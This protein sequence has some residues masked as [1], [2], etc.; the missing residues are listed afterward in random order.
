MGLPFVSCIMPTWNRRAFVPKAIEYFLRQDYPNKELVILDDGA[1]NVRDL[2]PNSSSAQIKCRLSG[3]AA[4]GVK[5]NIL[6]REAQ[7]DLIAHWHDDDWY[8][9]QRLSRQVAVMAQGADICGLDTILFHDLP[10]DKTYVYHHPTKRYLFCS[11]VMYRR[12]FW[13]AQH[14]PERDVAS[15]S[16]FIWPVD[17]PHRL[18]NAVFLQDADWFVG[19]VHLDNHNRKVYG[20]PFYTPYEG[21]VRDV[22]GQDWEFYERLRA[23]LPPRNVGRAA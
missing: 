6:V 17:N 15:S 13:D 5:R 14:F 19:M 22:V 1:D 11:T 18:D 23:N 7:G 2:V 12:S 9:P 4:L 21:D 8:G 20:R 3:K 16:P 10:T